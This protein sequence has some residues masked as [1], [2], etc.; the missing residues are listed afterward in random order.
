MMLP[1]LI[2][3][4]FLLINILFDGCLRPNSDSTYYSLLF[5]YDFNPTYE[6]SSSTSLMRKSSLSLSSLL[7]YFI[8][9]FCL[10]IPVIVFTLSHDEIGRIDYPFDLCIAWSGVCLIFLGVWLR[11]YA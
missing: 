4:I 10:G 7:I 6:Y 1:L 11:W 2:S 8:Y 3:Y 9:L 5:D